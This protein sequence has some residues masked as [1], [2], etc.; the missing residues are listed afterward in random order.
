MD[1]MLL[2]KIMMFLIRMPLYLIAVSF[3]EFGHAYAAYRQGDDTAKL[4]GRLTLNPMAHIDP[5]GMLCF[6]LASMTGVGFGWA[7]PVPIN[8]LRFREYR[9][10][11]IEVSIAGVAMNF[12]LFIVALIV[13]KIIAMMGLTG[14]GDSALKTVFGLIYWFIMF[15]AVLFVFNLIPV[16]PLDGSKILMMFLPRDMAVA[17]AGLERYG[18]M[19]ILLMISFRIL[20][21]VF[22]LVFFGVQS[23]LQLIL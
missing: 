17:F 2:E 10:G 18:F 4:E 14:I 6:F 3:H 5:V 21:P 22:N 15:N 7:K 16:P 23:L 11:M 20:D 12:L 8:P 1:N 9:K 19:I 13:V